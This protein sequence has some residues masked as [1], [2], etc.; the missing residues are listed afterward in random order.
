M[1][2]KVWW[3]WACLS[4]AGCIAGVCAWRTTHTHRAA[5][6]AP[7]TSSLASSARWNPQAAASY[8]DA[9]EKWWQDWAPTH[10]EQGTICI[11]CHTA[12]PYAIVRPILRKD[13]RETEIAA[14]EKF[15]LDSI[16]RRVGHWSEMTPFYSDAIDGPGK[17][18]QSHATEA[19]LNAVI[20][21]SRDSQLG[22]LSPI[23]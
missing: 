17:T 21:A 22:K 1:S 11:S 20:L 16:V 5:N 3:T 9:R 10:R 4:L 2:S 19:V 8:L 18:N 6:I 12:V 7:T 13:L 23:T 14:P 15:L